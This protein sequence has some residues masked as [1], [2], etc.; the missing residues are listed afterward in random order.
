MNSKESS[1]KRKIHIIIFGTDTPAG[2]AFD[3]VLL[4]AILISVA[5]IML[6]SVNSI[7]VRYGTELRVIEWVITGLFTVEYIL[8]IIVTNRKKAYIFSFMG[9]VDFFSILPTFLVLLI[10]GTQFLASVRILRLIR[11]FRILKLTRYLGAAKILSTALKNSRLKIFVFLITV[12]LVVTII[13]SVMYVV[14]G[15]ENGFKSIPVSIYWT[16]VTVTTVGYGDISPQTPLGQLLASLTMIIG[17]SIIAIPTGVVTAEVT[18]Q[19]FDDE[20]TARKKERDELS[21]TC[22]DCRHNN[23]GKANYCSNCGANLAEQ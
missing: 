9:L 23:P 2:K 3:L 20:R 10:P 15:P 11:I 8:R 22:P 6:E 7:K 19:T 17:Y 12:V 21:L 16:I 1:L 13:G 5:A 4:V 18:K 14:E